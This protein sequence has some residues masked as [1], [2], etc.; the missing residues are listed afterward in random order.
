MTRPSKTTELVCSSA[1]EATQWFEALKAAIA[2]GSGQG[3]PAAPSGEK[4]ELSERSFDRQEVAGAA[5]SSTKAPAAMGAAAGGY[6][7]GPSA[8]SSAPS[9]ASGGYPS[10]RPAAAAAPL[11]RLAENAP[12]LENGD[13]GDDQDGDVPPPPIKGTFLDLTIEETPAESHAADSRTQSQVD[14]AVVE[15]GGTI[16]TSTGAEALQASDF[17]FGD[18]QDSDSSSAPSSPRGEKQEAAKDTGAKVPATASSSGGYGDKD[19]GLT[20][21]ERLANLQFSDDEDEDDD[22]PLGLKQSQKGPA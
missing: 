14:A 22:D 5:T 2:I 19:Q 15:D 10:G 4:R 13:E 16:V 18:D 17:G 9:Q 12:F 1:A 20:M 7:A 8:S 11:P 21:Q 3:Q 6:P